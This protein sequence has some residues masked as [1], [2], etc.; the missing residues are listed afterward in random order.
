[1][2]HETTNQFSKKAKCVVL[3][4]EISHKTSITWLVNQMSSC[5]KSRFQP[6]PEKTQSRKDAK[7]NFI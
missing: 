6:L 5:W 3:G 4:S 1:L 7:A 2:R